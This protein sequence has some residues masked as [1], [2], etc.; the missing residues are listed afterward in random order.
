MRPRQDAEGAARRRRVQRGRGNGVAG[1][2]P[3][4]ARM[5]AIDLSIAREATLNHI[6]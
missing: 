2:S 5:F 3:V 1:I 6:F 4:M